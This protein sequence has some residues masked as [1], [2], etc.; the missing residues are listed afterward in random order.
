[1]TTESVRTRDPRVQGIRTVLREA[2]PASDRQ[3]AGFRTL[4]RHGNPRGQPRQLAD[5]MDDFDRDT[6][7]AVLRPYR[8]TNAAA[9]AQELS[10][11]LRP[12][13]TSVLVRPSLSPA[14][15]PPCAQ[16]WII[17]VPGDLRARLVYP[18]RV[19][20]RESVGSASGPASPILR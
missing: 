4:L 1:V 11:V 18:P 19:F 10:A 14:P 7:R 3:A 12:L 8:A 2:G 6:R 13:K 20:G 9:S 15:R 17:E 16:I 5:G